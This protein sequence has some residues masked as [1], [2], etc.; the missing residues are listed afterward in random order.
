MEAKTFL[1]A[2]YKDVIN[3]FGICPCCGEIFNL[4]KAVIRLKKKPMELPMFSDLL[5]AQERIDSLE[6]EV[7][8]MEDEYQDRLYSFSIKEENYRCSK[9]EMSNKFRPKGQ[10]RALNRIKKID[11]VFTR[12]NIDPRDIRLVWSPIDFIAYNGMT[13]KKEID[14]IEFINHRPKSS[15]EEK[16]LISIERVIKKGDI[17]FVLIKVSDK[18]TVSYDSSKAIE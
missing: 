18:G 17:D 7:S 5:T 10:R 11:K 13:D 9:Q 8:D 12:L 2:Y 6:T 14:S 3:I 4:S 15:F 16:T 1:L